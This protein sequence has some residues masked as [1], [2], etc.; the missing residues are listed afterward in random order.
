MM[1]KQRLQ[2]LLKRSFEEAMKHVV[3]VANPSSLRRKV[4][5][6]RDRQ[7]GRERERRDGVWREKIKKAAARLVVERFRTGSRVQDRQWRSF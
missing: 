1:V 4:Q 5:E 2:E 6:E 3:V 7:R